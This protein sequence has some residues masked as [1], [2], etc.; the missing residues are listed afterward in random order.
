MNVFSSVNQMVRTLLSLGS[1]SSSCWLRCKRFN[2]QFSLSVCPIKRLYV[3]SRKSCCTIGLRCTDD[4]DIPF[5][6]WISHGLLWLWESSSWLHPLNVLSCSN[7]LWPTISALTFC[8][9]IVVNLLNNLTDSSYNIPGFVWKPIFHSPCIP[10]FLNSQI[11]NQNTVF[12]CI[13]CHSAKYLQNTQKLMID[14]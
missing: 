9:T 14:K 12:Y 13:F 1:R 4:H 8:Y 3:F 7:R 10:M 6:L 2:L 5:S 11:F